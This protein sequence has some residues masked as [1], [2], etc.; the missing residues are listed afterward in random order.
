[1]IEPIDFMMQYFLQSF[2]LNMLCPYKDSK[3]NHISILS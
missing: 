1:M 3:I 2:V